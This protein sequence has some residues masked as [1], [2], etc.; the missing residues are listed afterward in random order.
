MARAAW[1]CPAAARA[2]EHIGLH[3]D[4]KDDLARS[5]GHHRGEAANA[6]EVFNDAKLGKDRGAQAGIDAD[7]NKALTLRVLEKSFD[8]SL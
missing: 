8:L 6:R 3:V 7:A 4:S 1:L 5:I 2:R